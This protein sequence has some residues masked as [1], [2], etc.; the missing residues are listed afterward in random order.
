MV[1]LSV[2]PRRN[3]LKLI[4]QKIHE[5]EKTVS[6]TSIHNLTFLFERAYDGIIDPDTIDA[7]IQ[8]TVDLY[9][10]PAPNENAVSLLLY[11][12]KRFL[13]VIF[14]LVNF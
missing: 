4:V 11:L 14:S 12:G 8:Q 1:S 7:L 9:Q 13:D 10:M 2:K 5:R 6:L 3:K